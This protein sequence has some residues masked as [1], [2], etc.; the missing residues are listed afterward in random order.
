ME[1]SSLENTHIDDLVELVEP[2]LQY[3]PD[4]VYLTG[5]SVNSDNYGDIDVAINLSNDQSIS[6]IENYLL[7]ELN[8]STR[9][10]TDESWIG[11]HKSVVRGTRDDVSYDFFIWDD[12]KLLDD[13]KL[14]L[15]AD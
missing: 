2:I 7:K 10:G 15:A 14:I 3:S 1:Q 9:F 6:K 13:E 11:K 4:E 12:K 5:S 8:E